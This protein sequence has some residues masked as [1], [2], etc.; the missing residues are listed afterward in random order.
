MPFI[1]FPTGTVET[2]IRMQVAGVPCEVTNGWSHGAGAAS[3]ADGQNLADAIRDFI[4]TTIK[5]AVTNNVIFTEVVAI[6]LTSITGWTASSVVATT[7]SASGTPVQNQVAMVVT[8]GTGHRGRS[9]RGR[10]YWPGLS[11][12]NLLD[13]TN[14]TSGAVAAWDSIYSG[15][16]SAGGV[17]GFSLGVLSRFAAG[18][19]RTT[20][21]FNTVLSYRANQPL[22]TQRG[23]LT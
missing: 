20:G 6:D 5:T 12:G 22:G 9:Y 18:A 13:T 4:N 3:V 7:G 16:N 15:L 17:V 23:R 14:W 19:P 11:A 2:L 21:M 8:L 1:P 10:N